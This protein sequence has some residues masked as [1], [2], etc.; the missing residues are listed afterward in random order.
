MDRYR[1]GEERRVRPDALIAFAVGTVVAYLIALQLRIG[2][3]I[4]LTLLVAAI[5]GLWYHWRKIV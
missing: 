4:F 3:R 5:G 2:G 1:F